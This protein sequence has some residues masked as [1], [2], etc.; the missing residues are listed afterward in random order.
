MALQPTVTLPPGLTA[1]PS[2]GRS[3]LLIGELLV[4]LGYAT[5]DEVH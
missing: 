2:R 4:Q 5:P 1:P 3:R